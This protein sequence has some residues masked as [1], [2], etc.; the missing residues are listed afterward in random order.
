MPV[1]V[2]FVFAGL[3]DQL[4]LKK[5]RRMIVAGAIPKC[6]SSGITEDTGNQE[7]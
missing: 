4:F 7:R 6:T 3:F 5:L 1:P 2:P